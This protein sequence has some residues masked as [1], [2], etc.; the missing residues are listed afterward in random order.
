MTGP[1][2]A[3]HGAATS[4][5]GRLAYGALGLVF[6]GLGIAWLAGMA[7]EIG[8]RLAWT[9]AEA[10]ILEVQRGTPKGRG[11]TPFLL[12]L[13]VPREAA[14]PE[15]PAATFRLVI[16]GAGLPGFPP[17][18]V[19]GGTV[20]VLR[21]PDEP[22]RLLLRDALRPLW[23]GAVLLLLPATGAILL[24]LAVALPDPRG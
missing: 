17:A 14:P 1:V 10:R 3:R 7:E 2:E 4:P 23:F 8:A 9:P 24:Y 12:R 22:G 18:P 19:P 11:G 5:A 6:L 21:H 13:E 20:A 16:P 15:R